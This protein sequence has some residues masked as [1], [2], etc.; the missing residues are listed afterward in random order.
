MHSMYDTGMKMM[1]SSSMGRFIEELAHSVD[2]GALS[3][4]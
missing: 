3:L 4:R 2:P 1:T